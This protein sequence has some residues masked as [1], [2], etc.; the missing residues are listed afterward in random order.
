MTA[1]YEIPSLLRSAENRFISTYRLSGSILDLGGDSKSAY[2]DVFDKESEVTRINL[3]EDS[4][5]DLVHDLENPIPLNDDSYDS[6]L[7]MNVLEH[8][9]N[10][11]QLIFE[12][13]RLLRPGGRLLAVVPFMFPVHPSPQD[14]WRMT[15]GAIH[16]ELESVGFESIQV[17][18]LGKGVFSMIYVCIDRLMPYPLRLISYH[19]LRYAVLAADML[20]DS[21]AKGSGRKYR[22]SD[23][24]LGFGITAKKYE[25]G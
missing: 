3:D 4:R 1:R 11:S 18:P 20:F 6:V 5:P 8:V 21:I 17:V 25:G 9:Y 2:N 23:Y 14:F 22:A 10:K 24:A 15:S 7:L 19:T 16:R 13:H 12:A